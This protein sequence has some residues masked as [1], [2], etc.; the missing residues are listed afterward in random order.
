MKIVLFCVLGGL[1]LF[2]GACSGNKSF[3]SNPDLRQKIAFNLEEID[4]DGLIGPPD[5]KRS[6]AYIFYIPAERSKQHEVSRIDHSVRFFLQQ[7]SEEYQ[8]MGEGATQT[9]LLR[10]ACLDYIVQIKPFYGE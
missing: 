3:S 2:A 5:G 6:V 4:D 9:T 10:L 7:G 1:G 8:C